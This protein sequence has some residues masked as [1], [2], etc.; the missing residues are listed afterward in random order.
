[1]QET[2][3]S[4]SIISSME[5]S[6][7]SAQEISME[8]SPKQAESFSQKMELKLNELKHELNRLTNPMNW[9]LGR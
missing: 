6:S 5:D 9:I 3:S 4:S 2:P 1:M 8:M 7:S